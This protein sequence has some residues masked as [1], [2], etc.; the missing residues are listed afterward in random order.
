MERENANRK[1]GWGRGWG[2]NEPK[3]RPL[4]SLRNGW[5]DGTVDRLLCGKSNTETF[6]QLSGTVQ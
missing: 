3:E 4:L 6:V 1:K 5:L 2:V